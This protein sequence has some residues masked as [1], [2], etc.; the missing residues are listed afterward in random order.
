[1]FAYYSQLATMISAIV[2]PVLGDRRTA[3]NLLV[4]HL[5]YKCLV[6]MAL[7]LWPRL[8]K[9]DKGEFAKLEPWVC[10]PC[11]KAVNLTD[12][13]WTV[14]FLQLFQSSTGQL[15][16]LS[17][18]RIHLVIALRASGT[19]DNLTLLSVD[20]LTRHV[21]LF[22]KFFRRL[23]QLEPAKFVELPTGNEIVLYYW[24]RVVQATNGPPELIQ[25]L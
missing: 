4:A 21:R 25:G 23:Q 17:E 7:W 15:K 10:V 13:L 3:D 5:V 20:R 6:K 16:I 24:D 22:G 14:Q 8:I 1:M 11:E 19:S 2:P 18:L 9:P 12:L